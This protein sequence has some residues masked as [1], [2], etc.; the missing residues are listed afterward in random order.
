M[1][2][3]V[4]DDDAASQVALRQLLTRQVGFHGPPSAMMGPKPS[5]ID[6]HRPD[7]VFATGI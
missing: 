3:L 6:T 2:V 1:R 4:C 7:L 5:L